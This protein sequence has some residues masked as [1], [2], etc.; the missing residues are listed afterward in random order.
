MTTGNDVFTDFLESQ[1]E[2]AFNVALDQFGPTGNQRNFFQNE[3]QNILNQFLGVLGGQAQAGETPNALFTDFLA[4]GTVL[5]GQS[6][7]GFQNTFAT[8]APSL[9]GGP[10]RNLFAPPSRSF[11]F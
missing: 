5:P 7:F 4:G 2:T 10:A 8:T 3:F 1:P 9:R 6:P 11:F